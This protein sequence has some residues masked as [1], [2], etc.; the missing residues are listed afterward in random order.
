MI[1]SYSELSLAAY[2]K[3]VGVLNDSSLDGV[4]KDLSILNILSGI[5]M[6]ELRGMSVYDIEGMLEAAKFLSVPLDVEEVGE[7]D[8]DGYHFVLGYNDITYS[9]YVDVLHAKDSAGVL[10]AVCVPV[11]HKYN[12]GYDIDFGGMDL[13]LAKGVLDSFMHGLR[14]SVQLTLKSFR[15]SLLRRIF[16]KRFRQVDSLIQR[17]VSLLS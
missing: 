4:E 2:D 10:H 9:Q 13:S 8:Y 17:T 15:P 14:G 11:G 12:D 5:D 6:D 3:V 16:S 7:F 1:S